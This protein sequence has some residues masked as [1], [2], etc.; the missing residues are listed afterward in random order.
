MKNGACQETAGE[1]GK[2]ERRVCMCIFVC[3]QC[4]CD[5]AADLF[6]AVSNLHITIMFYNPTFSKAP[7]PLLPSVMQF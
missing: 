3:L 1:L 5:G 6:L 7:P 4:M 2:V